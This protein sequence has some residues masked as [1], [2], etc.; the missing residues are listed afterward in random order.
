MQRRPHDDAG[1]DAQRPAQRRRQSEASEFGDSTMDYPTADYAAAPGAPPHYMDYEDDDF[2]PCSQTDNPPPRTPTGQT[3]F[4]AQGDASRRRHEK[5]IQD[6]VHGQITLHGM[7]VAVMDTV[8]FQRLDRIKQLGGCAYVYPSATHT[9]K[10]HSIGVAYL[11]GMMARHLQEQQPELDIAPADVLCV[12]LAGLVHDLGHGP[13]SHMFE[14]FMKQRKASGATD[15][16]EHED[17]S[18]ALFRLLLEENRIPTHDYF[19]C[20]EGAAAAHVEFVVQLIHGLKDDKAWPAQIGRPPTK[21]FLFDIVSNARNGID[22]DK[23]DYLVRDSMACFGSPKPPGFDIYRIIKSSRVLHRGH[24]PLQPEVCYQ[25]KNALEICETYT[26]RA[27]LHRMVYQHRI[28]NVAE[29][30]ITDAL[31]AADEHFRLRATLEEGGAGMRLSQAAHSARSFAR[32]NDSILDAIDWSTAAGLHK[33]HALLER[34]KK[35]DFYRQVGCEV[36]IVTQ[37]LCA[38]CGG[39]T[40]IEDRFCGQCARRTDTRKSVASMKSR[41]LLVPPSMILDAEMAKGE[42]MRKLHAIDPE[43][44]AQVEA[45]DALYVKLV[46]ITHGKPVPQKDPWG[47][48]WQVYDPLARVGFYNPKDVGDVV[49]DDEL[50]ALAAQAAPEPYK[51]VHMDRARLPADALP[52]E[53]HSR[54]LYCF[55]RAEGPETPVPGAPGPSSSGGGGASGAGG[56]GGGGGGGSLGPPVPNTKG[57]PGANLFIVRK[58]RT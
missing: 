7:L 54:T 43:V 12:E 18:G 26:L 19:G 10:E 48:D 3:L 27:R 41:G 39:V 51:I 8:E 6:R 11:A 40:K 24:D 29:A 33:S 52:Q 31:I 14:E 55:L 13:F 30:M 21:R 25:M 5:S 49:A 16:W 2:P 44:G 23:L 58:V 50:A 38:K 20:S 42:I 22:V 1:D 28:G 46:E 15:D 36:K 56:G 53:H 57:P 4:E 45:D 17:M 37:P 32:L 9:R 34:L 35:R 47:C